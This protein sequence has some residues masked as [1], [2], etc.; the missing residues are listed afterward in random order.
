MRSKLLRLG[1]GCAAFSG[2]LDGLALGVAAA[3][4][5]PP[6]ASAPAAA[7]P[8]TRI[9]EGTDR[10]GVSITV[11]NSDFGL[12]REVRKLIGLPKGQVALEFRDVASTIQPETVAVKPL[13]GARVRVLE[14]N[15][16]FDL[17][18]PETLLEKYVGRSV[19]AYRYHEATGKEDVADAKLLSVANGP[20]LQ[21]GSEITF[22]YPGRLAFKELPPN[23]IAKP[24]LVWLVESGSP[25]PAL[26][27]SYLAQQL[28]WSADY[29]LVLD[30]AEKQ[31]GL[32]GWVTLVNNS[33]ASYR[34]ASL[35]LVAGDVHRVEPAANYALGRGRMAAEAAPMKQQFHEEG[36]LEYHLYTLQRPTDV[37]DKEQKQVTLL[38]A[39]AVGIDKKLI[40]AG[41]QDWYQSQYG[42]LVQ[43]QKVS[44][45]LDFPN[46]EQNHLGMPLPK[47]TVRV[48]KADKSGGKQ[49]VGEDSIDHTPRDEKVRIKVGEA[50][51]VVADRKQTSW[52]SLGNC[53]SES[54]WQVDLR[55]HKDEDVKVEVREPAG[56]DWTIVNSSL[57]AQRDDA[58]S[59]HFDVSVP[60]RGATKVTYRVR[61]RWC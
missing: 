26:E 18:T 59:F 23:L 10:R 20:I 56:G 27:V 41:E 32:V 1:L 16:R 43:N 49:F 4:P 51:D 42:E 45:Y 61:V 12:V 8:A 7:S 9:S 14:Q 29:V 13:E 17:L 53:S 24:T 3:A 2:V 25:D 33:G 6:P 30:E 40:F 60:K 54:A 57:P 11:Y 28:S 19:R 15:Y 21:I 36:L 47:G 35:Q 48:Y 39:S 50:F 5:A 58:R 31:A 22:N 38:E 37:L 46:S 52:S 55:N 44:V 34:G